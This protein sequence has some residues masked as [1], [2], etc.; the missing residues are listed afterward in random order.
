MNAA[1]AEALESQLIVAS[2]DVDKYKGKEHG[3]VIG[4]KRPQDHCPD[5]EPQRDYHEA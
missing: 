1:K 5:I 3:P 2:E 4:P